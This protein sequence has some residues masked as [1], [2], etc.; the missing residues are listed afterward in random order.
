MSDDK[1][2]R[3]RAALN[4]ADVQRLI[5]EDPELAE[6]AKKSPAM[7]LGMQMMQA[8]DPTEVFETLFKAKPEDFPE[9][10]PMTY[11]EQTREIMK[12]PRT[13]DPD[14]P[15]R[16]DHPDFWTLSRIINEM[17][18]RS[19]EEE[20]SVSNVLVPVGVDPASVTYMARQRALRAE[21]QLEDASLYEKLAILWLDAFT[22]GALYAQEKAPTVTQLL[23]E[24]IDGSR[25]SG[26]RSG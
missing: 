21:E 18:D 6:I 3:V 7:A 17:D 13:M 9:R 1:E 23:D 20:N 25:R 4:D 12:Q 8:Q 11:R 22:A 5:G 10:E 26:G 14:V 24:S 19:M 15:Y 16:P 2:T